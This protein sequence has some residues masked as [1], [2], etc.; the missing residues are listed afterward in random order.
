MFERF[1]W[2][3][4]NLRVRVT[5]TD[6]EMD[7]NSLIRSGIAFPQDQESG[8]LSSVLQLLLEPVLA[9]E[10]DTNDKKEDEK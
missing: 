3:S 8:S 9:V 10:I 1:S 5:I 6:L 7:Q 2:P 4:V